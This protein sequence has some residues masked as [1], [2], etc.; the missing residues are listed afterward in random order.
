MAP[1]HDNTPKAPDK[2]EKIKIDNDRVAPTAGLQSRDVPAENKVSR[3][4]SYR[5][6]FFFVRCSV[7]QFIFTQFPNY[8]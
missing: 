3:N 4:G 2:N 1:E 7:E 8:C 6:S 5:I